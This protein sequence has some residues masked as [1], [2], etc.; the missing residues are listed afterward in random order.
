MA[1]DKSVEAGASGSEEVERR[2]AALGG[3]RAVALQR[4]RAL[5]KEVEPGVVEECKWRGTPVWSCEG[6]LCTGE[7]YRDKVKLTFQRGA[8]LAD[9]H[10]LFNAS[11]E[12]N[13]RRAIDIFE[14]QPVDEQAF[15]ALV[16][17]AI[18]LNRRLKR[19]KA[20]R[21]GR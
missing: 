20:A 3:W 11:L 7:S 2:I 13:M 4:M 15:R 18:D 6:M 19:A 1:A 16:R 9:P 21:P 17:E 5:I 10:R 14:G 8:A 12:G